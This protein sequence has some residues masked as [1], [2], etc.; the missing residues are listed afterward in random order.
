MTE[1]KTRVNPVLLRAYK[2]LR[3][4]YQMTSA[5]ALQWARVEVRR[6]ELEADR[7]IT[8]EVIPS[9]DALP[10]RGNAMASGDPDLDK[11]VEE[12]ITDRLAKGDVWAWASVEVKVTKGYLSESEYLG[13]CC[14]RDED[15]FRRGGYFVDMVETCLENIRLHREEYPAPPSK[16]VD[17]ERLT[18][19]FRCVPCDTEEA[20]S[21]AF[22][23]S[24]SAMFPHCE[25]CKGVMDLSEITLEEEA[26]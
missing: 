4:K 25:Q 24:N 2:D 22:F 16:V 11:Q 15:D 18:L 26:Q 6:Q 1:T 8:I 21:A 20:C 19:V 7:S 10:V 12:E 14:Y 17:P 9:F 13:A 5:A 23:F 3:N